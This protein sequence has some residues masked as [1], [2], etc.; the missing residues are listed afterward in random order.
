MP[1]YLFE[2]LLTL[3]LKFFWACDSR[4]KGAHASSAKNKQ[5]RPVTSY[6]VTQDGVSY[7]TKPGKYYTDILCRDPDVYLKEKANVSTVSSTAHT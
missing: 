5:E 1:S 3:P 6:D 2:S 4:A 7:S